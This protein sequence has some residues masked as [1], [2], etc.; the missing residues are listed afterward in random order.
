MIGRSVHSRSSIYSS[1][2]YR[3]FVTSSDDVR[4]TLDECRSLCM[5]ALQH[6]GLVES[7]ANIIAEVNFTVFLKQC[8]F[9]PIINQKNK[10]ST[11]YSGGSA[12]SS[13]RLKGTRHDPMVS[14]AWAASAML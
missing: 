1:G 11:I 14:F 3:H 9:S 5:N 12:R 6:C 2:L 4:M 10:I 8:Y 7:S 13:L